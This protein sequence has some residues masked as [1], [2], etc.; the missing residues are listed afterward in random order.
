MLMSVQKNT[1]YILVDV[2]LHCY[3]SYDV[4]RPRIT[5]QIYQTEC[6]LHSKSSVMSRYIT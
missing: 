2:A 3:W 1:K 6:W 5:F 4:M